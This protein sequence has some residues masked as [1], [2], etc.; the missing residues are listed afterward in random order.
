MIRNAVTLDQALGLSVKELAKFPID[1]IQLLLEDVAA[2]KLHAKRVDDHMFAVLTERYSEQASKARAAKG[3]DTGTVRLQDGE[4]VIV[5]DLPKKVS[6]DGDGLAQVAS[7]LTEMG[8]PIGDYI[9]TKR[10]VSE[11]AF[12]GWPTS[13]KK[14]FLP[15][16]TVSVGKAGFKIERKKDAA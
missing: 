6:W 13:L 14:L 3:S 10:D 9:I 11:R 5:A 12:D 8:E 2:L 4:F 16:R 15:Y 7:Q 1:Q